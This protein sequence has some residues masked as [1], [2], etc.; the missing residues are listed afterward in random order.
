MN[1]LGF[2]HRDP[3][4]NRI[5]SIV[6]GIYSFWCQS[7]P[8]NPGVF[9]E[10]LKTFDKL[11]HEAPFY[12]LKPMSVSGPVLLNLKTHWETGIRM[13]FYIIWF[14]KLISYKIPIWLWIYNLWSVK[15]KRMIWKDIKWSTWISPSNN[16]L[17]KANIWN[18]VLWTIRVR[19]T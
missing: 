5:L 4:K 11:R 2:R 7:W 3:Y 13:Y 15:L 8:W 18:Y 1:Q 14:P 12:K 17:Y 10:M 6:L 19:I 16:R 9:L